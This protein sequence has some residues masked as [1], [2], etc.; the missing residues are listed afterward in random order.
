MYELAAS[1]SD[2][3]GGEDQDVVFTDVEEVLSSSTDPEGQF[4]LHPHLRCASHTLNLISSNDVDKWLTANLES[5]SVY[6]SAAGKI[7]ALWTKTSCS[8]VA[9]MRICVKENSWYRQQEDGTHS[10]MLCPASLT[11]LSQS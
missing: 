2:E 4:S 8:T 1:D 9:L 6:R 5:K 10:M 3:E 7:S 11:F